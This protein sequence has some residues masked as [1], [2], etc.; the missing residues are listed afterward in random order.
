MEAGAAGGSG[1][2]AAEAQLAQVQ[3]ATN[4]STKRTIAFWRDIIFNAAG[5]KLT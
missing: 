4:A 1:H 5:S 3:L 2:D